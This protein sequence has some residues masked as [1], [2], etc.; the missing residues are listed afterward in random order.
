MA[1][2]RLVVL[3]S[4]SGT[5]LQALL[6]AIEAHPGG[7]EGFGAE[8][9]AVGADRGNIAGLERA[10]KAGIPTFVCPVKDYASREEWD[11]ALTEA[12]DAHAPDL[13]VSAGFM[14]IVG[15]SFIDR[16]GGRFVNTHPALLPAFPGAH[17]VRDALAYGAKVTGCTVHF[18]DSGVD[19]GPIIAQGVVEIRDG[20][21]EAALHERI[22]EV[23]RQLLV[24]VVGRLA[25]HGYRIE[26]RKV[27][28]Q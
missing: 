3:V 8:V 12:T 18:V 27:T 5:N 1:A 23:E 6:D 20:E 16:F 25:R 7:A 21:D 4:G 13:V 17:G 24:D 10:E 11:A 14:K 9:V 26:G 19:T 22:K 15:K 28:I 2:S